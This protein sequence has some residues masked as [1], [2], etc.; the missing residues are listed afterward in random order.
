MNSNRPVIVIPTL[1]PSEK[2]VA[3]VSELID[4][5]FDKILVVNDGSHD[6]YNYIFD[7][8]SDMPQCQLL[9]H[10]ENM[11]KGRALKDALAYYS[12]NQ[13]KDQYIGVITVDS[14]GQHSVVDVTRLWKKLQESSGKLI[15]GQRLFDKDVPFRSKFGNSITS[16]LFKLLY[17]IKLKETQ[18]GL[19]GI[20]NE[21]INEFSDIKG[22]RY[23]YEMNMLIMCSHKKIGI[24]SIFIETIYENNNEG[25]HFNPIRDS[26]K[27]Y[28]LLLGSFVKFT[29][30]SLSSSLIDIGL[31]QLLVWALSG[32]K[33]YILYSTIGARVV[34]SLFN[35][36]V[37]RNVVFGAKDNVKS[38]MFRYYALCVVQALASAG[39]VTLFF[40]VLPLPELIVKMVV[41]T[42]LFFVS[43][44][45]HKRWVFR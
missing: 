23:E 9:V 15:L 36:F 8:L 5:G 10:K 42:L 45:I 27:I 14:D 40:S 12:D 18:T 24:D 35:F 31:F 44:L 17:G 30:S 20:P 28:A 21:L 13:L 26:A 39:L 38:T 43:F 7:Q 1:N 19:R 41:D 2:L 37:N 4:S 3:Y 6:K 33:H 16:V 25:S 34:S 32:V 11:G 22:E 29:L